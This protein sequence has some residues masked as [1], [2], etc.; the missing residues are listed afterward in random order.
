VLRSLGLEPPDH[1]GLG[2]FLSE[3]GWFSHLGGAFGFFSGLFGSL[4]GGHGIVAMT[5]G[6]A[7]PAFFGPLVKIAG[8][9]GWDGFSAGIATR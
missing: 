7:T 5:A 1:I 8:E 4:E 9:F 3:S 2:L 6:G